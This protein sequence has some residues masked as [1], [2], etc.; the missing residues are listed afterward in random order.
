MAYCPEIRM[1]GTHD[2]SYADPCHLERL[3]V[4]KRVRDESQGIAVE[5]QALGT[6]RIRDVTTT[7]KSRPS[8][9]YLCG[10]SIVVVQ[11]AAQP[12][13]PLYRTARSQV[14]RLGKNDSI[15]Q[16][17]VVS[18]SMIMRHEILDDHL[19]RCLSKQNHSIQT[20]FFDAPHKPVVRKKSVASRIIYSRRRR[21]R[22]RS[23]SG[24]M[25]SSISRRQL[26]IQRSA[27]PFCH[28]ARMLVR[29]G[30]KPVAV[31]N[32]ITSTL[33]FES[34]SKMM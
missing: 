25:W 7:S 2:G 5:P 27:V 26:P 29:F 20:R 13:P 6:S 17:L 33:N 21:R 12:L 16:S 18:L 15:G 1:S 11:H 10:R 3:L 9:N 14:T 22:C 34:W 31:N 19:E 24:M 23:F 32:Q 30:C 28:G 4:G 8:S